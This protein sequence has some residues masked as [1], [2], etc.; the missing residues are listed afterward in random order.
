MFNFLIFLALGVVAGLLLRNKNKFLPYIEKTTRY[1]IYLLLLTV[2]IKAGADKSITSQ[3]HTLGL[4]AFTITMF[5]VSGSVL[6]VW[7]TYYVIL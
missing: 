5:I 2:G 1:V 4:T 7:L 6:A 3:I